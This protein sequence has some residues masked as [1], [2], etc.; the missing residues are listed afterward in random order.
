MSRKTKAARHPLY[1]EPGAWV[2]DAPNVEPPQFLAPGA[3]VSS[4][5]VRDEWIAYEGLGYTVRLLEAKSLAD[6]RL[7]PLWRQAQAALLRI[8]DYLETVP[9]KRD[10]RIL[11]AK[12]R[13]PSQ[14]GEALEIGDNLLEE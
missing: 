10:K 8:V 7:R 4:Q 11:T 14:S 1:P 3:V 6:G 2:L 5:E 9:E 12:Q 13:K